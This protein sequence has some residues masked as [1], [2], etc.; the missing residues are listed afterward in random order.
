M[1]GDDTTEAPLDPPAVVEVAD[2]VFAFVQPDGTWFVNN[3]GFVVGDDH[4]VLI[5]T[6]ATE[7]RTRALLEA[8]AATTDSPV[9]V[10][11]NT[12]HHGDHTHGN[13]LC[14]DATIVGHQRCR[15]EVERMGIL[16]LDSVWGAVDWGDLQLRPPDLTFTDGI[17][18]S[19]GDLTLEVRAFGSAAHTT[20]DVVVWVPERRVLFTGDLVF[21]GGTPFVVMG[22]IAG[23]LASLDWL[24]SFAP[25]VIVPGH[26]PVC[27]VG[28]LDAIEDYLRFVAD[29]AER[30]RADGIAP[31]ALAEATDLG[32]FA[33]LT[34]PE[35][36]VANLHR[37]YA[38]AEGT[39]PGDP[40]DYLTAFSDML[41]LN[42]GGPLRCLA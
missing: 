24:R 14:G 27:D 11:V 36:L 42:G 16:T 41:A 17:D 33:G 12:H 7:R 2:D 20:N 4:V 21:H 5:D 38:E 18:L 1:T 10:V 34:D 25:D 13:F 6:C 23:S 3:A 37:A 26:G 40:I 35:R 28:A 39:P 30:G 15:E 19:V 31:L 29:L 9:R 8:V 32:R 22:S